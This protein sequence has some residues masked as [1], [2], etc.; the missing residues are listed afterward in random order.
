MEGT[1]SCESRCHE[2]TG[3]PAGAAPAWSQQAFALHQKGAVRFCRI[4]FLTH[5]ELYL[6]REHV[7]TWLLPGR[8]EAGNGSSYSRSVPQTHGI[9]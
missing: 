2:G 4:T 6:L 1:C 7:G 5:P 8:E 3:L 9:L